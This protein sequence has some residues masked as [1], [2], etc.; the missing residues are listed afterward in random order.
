MLGYHVQARRI[1]THGS[2]ISAKQATLLVDTGPPGLTDAFNLVEMLLGALAACMIKGTERVLP[3]LGFRPRNLEVKLHAVR[4]DIPPKIL[5]IDYVITID[6][7][8][9]D[10]RVVLL[11]TNAAS[12]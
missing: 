12:F 9:P 11:Q 3:T 4:Q 1:D 2:E 8:E 7:D 5:S 6:T 10:H